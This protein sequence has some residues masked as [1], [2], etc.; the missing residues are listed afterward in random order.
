[1]PSTGTKSR[2]KVP[3]G[4]KKMSKTS[5]RQRIQENI[6]EKNEKCMWVGNGQIHNT[7]GVQQV[8]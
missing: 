3:E 6:P 5:A 8:V 1:M 7:V 4:S 2:W